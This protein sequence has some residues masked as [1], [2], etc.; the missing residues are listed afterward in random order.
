MAQSVDKSSCFLITGLPN[1]Q[2]IEPRH[3][4]PAFCIWEN[5]DADQLRGNREA[6]QRLCFRYMDSIIPLQ[7]NRMTESQKDRQGKSS[8]A[9]LNYKGFSEITKTNLIT[10]QCYVAW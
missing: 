1:G 7:N 6:D 9:P 8:I 2:L 10:L 3:E 5:K 4:K